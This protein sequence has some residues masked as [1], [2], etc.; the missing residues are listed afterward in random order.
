MKSSGKRIKVPTFD[1]TLKSYDLH[2]ELSHK[3]KGI[4][5]RHHSNYTNSLESHKKWIDSYGTQINR[6]IRKRSIIELDV[7]ER[8]MLMLLI[9]GSLKH[10][11]EYIL[12]KYCI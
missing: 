6:I 12:Q 4:L 10:E 5:G 2:E 11:Y 3:L 7:T 8:K 9:E 1:G